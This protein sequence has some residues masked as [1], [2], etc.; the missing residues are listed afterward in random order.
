MS[1]RKQPTTTIERRL[2]PLAM[3]ALL[4]ACGSDTPPPAAETGPAPKGES[5]A[6]Y[7]D[8]RPDTEPYRLRVDEIDHL[9]KQTGE[10]LAM[11]P[12]LPRI[13]RAAS[14]YRLERLRDVLRQARAMAVAERFNQNAVT[15][16]RVLRDRYRDGA[17]SPLAD[18]VDWGEKE[19]QAFDR[20]MER[21]QRGF[22]E[23]DSDHLP[24]LET[25]GEAP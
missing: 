19:R 17:F 5:A 21:L 12:R 16:Y 23:H 9:L 8:H 3:A 25:D 4:S 18:D 10:D 24:W 7:D 11:L 1:P 6:A 14:T 13:D 15:K 2:V 22:G 20:D